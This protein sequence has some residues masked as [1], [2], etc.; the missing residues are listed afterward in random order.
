MRHVNF[1]PF[2]DRKMVAHRYVKAF[3]AG[4]VLPTL[5]VFGVGVAVACNFFRVP[6]AIEQAMLFPSALNPFL[7][8][9]WNVLYFALGK[10][11]L[12]LGWHGVLLCALLV[13]AGVFL[14]QYLQFEFVTPMRALAVFPPTAI[15]YYL[16]WRYGVAFLN[17]LLGASITGERCG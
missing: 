6:S 3:A 1:V 9:T 10:T 5:V 11:R 4:I 2:E 12:P 16:L 7:W 13:L 14:A 8:G 15:A 17:D